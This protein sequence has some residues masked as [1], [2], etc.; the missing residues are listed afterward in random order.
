MPAQELT[1]KERA[2]L[3]GLLAEGRAMT[4]TDLSA[5]AGVKL[6]GA[7]RLKL[8]DLKLVTSVK[9]GRGFVHELTEAGAQ[10]CDDE[11]AAERPER[12]GAGGGA[13]YAI[14]GGLQRYLQR[15]G[16]RLVDIFQPDDAPSGT[17]PATAEERERAAA[18]KV[19]SAPG[20]AGSVLGEAGAVL[21][22]E[23][24]SDPADR[25]RAAYARLSREPGESWLALRVLRAD[26][27]DL[28]RAEIDSALQQLSR[29]PGVH[30][31]AE[32]NQQSLTDEDHAAA[33]R[34]GA[35]SRHLLKIENP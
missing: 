18:E 7:S 1:L 20:E 3:L 14:L 30:V 2:V 5:A 24:G 34:F 12:A 6:D 17:A 29:E 21:G 13:L 22:E 32:A 11:L 15:T 23:L 27:A 10:W 33:V 16:Q 28:S 25:I 35:S 8:N 9:E 19:G 4:N 26:L 31:Q